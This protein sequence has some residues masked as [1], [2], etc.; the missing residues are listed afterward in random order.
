VKLQKLYLKNENNSG[1]TNNFVAV[2]ED[3]P[4][5]MAG[6]IRWERNKILLRHFRNESKSRAVRIGQSAALREDNLYQAKEIIICNMQQNGR[7]SIK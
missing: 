7:Q 4:T 1:S 2:D 5:I 3:M 6:W